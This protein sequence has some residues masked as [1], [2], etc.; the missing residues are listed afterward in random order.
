[1]VTDKRLQE[2]IDACWHG[3]D[4]DETTSDVVD[5]IGLVLK[6]YQALRE[7]AIEDEN[8]TVV[9]QQRLEYQRKLTEEAREQNK[10]LQEEVK[11]LTAYADKLIEPLDYLPKDIENIRKANFRLHEVEQQNKALIEDAERLAEELKD[12][13]GAEW[14]PLDV[15]ESFMKT[16]TKH[17][18][19]MEDIN[20]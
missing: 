3:E 16:L 12:T 19:L 1:M 4:G 18:E 10:E 13:L 20:E 5:E 17:K 14:S 8:T 15:P 9:G 7:Q 2:L 11:H 6:E